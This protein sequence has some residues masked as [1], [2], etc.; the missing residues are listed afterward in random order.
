M[1]D[2]DTLFTKRD[3]FFG[4]KTADKIGQGDVVADKEDVVD[5]WVELLQDGGP[6]DENQGF[7]ASLWSR[8]NLMTATVISG[9]TF[10]MV[11]Q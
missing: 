7:A 9:D 4:K 3:V 11:I 5:G 2:L 1:A 6:M 8:Y 10:L